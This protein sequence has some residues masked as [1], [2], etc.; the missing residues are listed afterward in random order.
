MSFK[1]EISLFLTTVSVWCDEVV[2][3]VQIW[4]IYYMEIKLIFSIRVWGAQNIHSYS[5]PGNMSINLTTMMPSRYDAKIW[6]IRKVLLFVYYI[7][8]SNFFF[9][10]PQ[11][12]RFYD[13]M[14]CGVMV[15]VPHHAHFD[16]IMSGI[17]PRTDPPRKKSKTFKLFY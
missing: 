4:F 11:Q 3:H 8:N 10:G 13:D 9:V 17:S 7:E 1:N 16:L 15:L 5:E 2:V 14:T 6:T 12:I